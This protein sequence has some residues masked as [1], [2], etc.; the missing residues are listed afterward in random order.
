MKRLV[1]TLSTILLVLL[2]PIM[3]NAQS[4]VIKSGVSIDGIN[5][6]GM[7]SE[8]AEQVVTTH[9]ADAK[10]ATLTVACVDDKSATLS[11]RDIGLTWTNTGIVKEATNVGNRGNAIRRYKD[12]KDLLRGGS[13]FKL[14]YTIDEAALATFVDEEC[15][16]FNNEAVNATLERGDSGFRVIPGQT[17]VIIDHDEAVAFLKDYIL[18]EWDGTAQVV[19]LPAQIDEPEGSTEDFEQITDLLGTYSTSYKTSGA[20][21]SANVANGCRLVNGTT[22]YPGEEFSMYEHIK[23]FTTEN[24]YMM[25]GSYMNGMVVDSLGGGICQVSTTLYNAVIRA[26]LEIV[27]RNNHSMIVTYVPPSADAAIAE[28]SGKDFR[29]V[30]NTDYP[31]YIEGYTTDEKR[32]VFNIYG[33]ETRPS[34]RTVEFESKT[35]ETTVP[36]VEN[37]IPDSSY[38]IGY[39]SVQSAH[40]GI[41]AELI[42]IVKVDGVEE[43]RE[44]FNSSNYKMVPRTAVVGIATTNP[45]AA[46]QISAAIASGSIDYT[47]GVAAAWAAQAVAPPAEAAP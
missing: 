27:E 41:K 10:N 9:V 14:Q 43:S 12:R 36:E 11:M 2:V 44:V 25:A 4:A 32:I 17:G 3:A 20:N 39:C 5:V 8:Q 26:E 45:E 15:M 28:S 29:F 35:L 38:P 24:G 22:L 31:I 7:T 21:R 13:N 34:N 46:S 19:Q 42:K 40:N 6:S 47:K 37:I 30:N 16:I 18:N 1:V 33:K 23:P